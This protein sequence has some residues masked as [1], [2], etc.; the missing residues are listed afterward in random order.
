[1][2]VTTRELLK[3][4]LVDD[5]IPEPLGGAHRDYDETAGSVKSYIL[6]AL[7]QFEDVDC[8]QLVEQRYTRL[9]SFGKFEV[10]D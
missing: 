9:M 7:R 4:G 6:D 5:V 1:M 2:G 10:K 3:A 8:E